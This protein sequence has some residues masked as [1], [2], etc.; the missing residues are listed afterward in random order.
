MQAEPNGRSDACASHRRWMP[1]PRKTKRVARPL[2]E[3]ATP[4][5]NRFGDLTECATLLR[6]LVRDANRWAGL[7][8]AFNEAARFEIL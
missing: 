4:A 7:H 6:E 1:R 3:L 8:L 2:R 5:L